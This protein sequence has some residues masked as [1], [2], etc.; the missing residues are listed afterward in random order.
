M[1][2][3]IIDYI[4]QK[5]Y[6]FDENKRL[7]NF[8]NLGNIHYLAY[9]YSTYEYISKRF[10]DLEQHVNIEQYKDILGVL[11]MQ[12]LIIKSNIIYEKFNENKSK[13]NILEYCQNKKNKI[14]REIR[15]I[16]ELNITKEFLIL[17]QFLSDYIIYEKIEELVINKSFPGEYSYFIELKETIEETEYQVNNTN[18]FLSGISLSDLKYEKDKK[19]RIFNKF[20]FEKDNVKKIQNKEFKKFMI[21]GDLNRSNSMNNLNMSII[22]SNIFNNS[23]SNFNNNNIYLEDI[24]YNRNEDIDFDECFSIDN[25]RKNNTSNNININHNR[26]ISNKNHQRKINFK[27]NNKY[28]KKENDSLNENSYEQEDFKLPSIQTNLNQRPMLHEEIEM[29]KQMVFNPEY[30]SQ[31]ARYILKFE[32]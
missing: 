5:Y 23:K 7:P 11:K 2:Q 15:S 25:V 3:T 17:I 19:E 14:T 18:Q 30:L 28:L 26:S 31:H 13:N 8:A 10:L 29:F 27:S 24:E 20:Y 32:K 9:Y 21:I 16:K 12:K 22:G 6:D 4:L 1:F